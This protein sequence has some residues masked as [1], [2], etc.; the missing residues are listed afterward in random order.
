MFLTVL[1]VPL[2][3]CADVELLSTKGRFTGTILAST[4]A[5]ALKTSKGQMT[6]PLDELVEIRFGKK[7]IED[8]Y[9]R[10]IRLH[11]GDRLSGVISKLE[12]E[13]LNVVTDLFGLVAVPLTP[14][15]GCDF[16]RTQIRHTKTSRKTHVRLANGD[17]LAGTLRWLDHANIGVK[18][19]LGLVNVERMRAVGIT[20]A[21]SNRAPRPEGLLAVVRF[22]SGDRVTGRWSAF[23]EE[24]LYLTLPAIGEV[25]FPVAAVTAVLFTGGKSSFLSDMKEASHE[26]GTFVP[27]GLPRHFGKDMSW[28]GAPIMMGGRRFEKGIS[29]HSRSKLTYSLDGKS[30]TFH[31][32]VGIDDEVSVMPGTGD[33]I[34]QVFVDGVKKFEQ[35]VRQSEKFIEVNVEV[36]GAKKISLV[37]EFGEG[38]DTGD[39][40]NWAMAR[41]AR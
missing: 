32:I 26:S 5:L 36:S 15:A 23:K 33:A 38:G 12:K 10:G 30:R 16:R 18:S 37:T 39:R 6:F 8:Y 25:H 22:R 2:I 40:V 9:E 3:E 24:Q 4:N 41:I 17:A 21:N 31:A 35:R 11:N 34:C 20:F 29:Q 19:S 7:P 13:K 14:L 27:G 1:L 28:G